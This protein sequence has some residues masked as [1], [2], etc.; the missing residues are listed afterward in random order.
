MAKIIWDE[1][2]VVLPSGLDSIS[3]EQVWVINCLLFAAFG[4]ISAG[5]LKPKKKE[6][7]R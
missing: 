4:D 7:E 5:K 1:S 2:H 3:S 6:I